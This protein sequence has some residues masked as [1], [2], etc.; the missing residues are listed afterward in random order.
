MKYKVIGSSSSGNSVIYFDNIM[1]DCGVSYNKIKNHLNNIKLIL[2]TH[3]HGDHYNPNTLHKIQE[4]YPHI[5]VACPEWLYDETIRLGF[6]NVIHVNLNV[7]YQ[8]KDIKISAFML[9]HNVVNCGWRIDKNN[10]K[11]FHATDTSTLDGISAKNYDLYAI[12][13]NYDA[14]TIQDVIDEKKRLKVYSYE[15]IAVDN[16]LSFQSAQKFINEN[17]KESSEVL[18]L[19]I[20]SRYSKIENETCSK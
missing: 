8:F 7:W 1:V 15:I 10:Y 2:L 13:H 3:R 4:T 5:I 20:S 14:D 11:I 16:H 6:K 18:K 9:Y 17:K 19:H 12:E